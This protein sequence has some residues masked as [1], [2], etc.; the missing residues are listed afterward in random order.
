MFACG[1]RAVGVSGY[2]CSARLELM[3]GGVR[4]LGVC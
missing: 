3:G 1:S 4:I 2:V